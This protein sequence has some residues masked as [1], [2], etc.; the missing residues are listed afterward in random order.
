VLCGA[1]QHPKCRC[2]RMW[3]AVGCRARGSGVPGEWP[4]QCAPRAAPRAVAVRRD[5]NTIRM[6]FYALLRP[7]WAGMIRRS[8]DPCRVPWVRAEPRRHDPL[9]VC[10][11]FARHHGHFSPPHISHHGRTPQSH[12]TSTHAALAYATAPPAP[13][14]VFRPLRSYRDTHIEYGIHAISVPSAVEACIQ[15]DICNP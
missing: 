7:D 1:R 9:P 10:V 13:L 11:T 3:K 8:S 14:S 12:H 5:S 4:R 15:Y 2:R 6:I